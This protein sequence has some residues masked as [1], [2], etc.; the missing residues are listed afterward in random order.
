MG[1]EPPSDDPQKIW[2]NQT[3]EIPQMTLE[4]VHEVKAK[5]LHRKTR[6]ESIASPA[7][8]ILMCMIVLAIAHGTVQRIACG[9]AILWTMI[10]QFPTIRRTW[11]RPPAGDEAS[12]TSLEFYRRELQHRLAY[13]RKPWRVW[14]GIIVP[15]VLVAGAL[16][17]PG[18]IAVAQ[19]PALF[20]NM[21]PF[22]TL[23][24]IWVVLLFRITRQQV[25]QIQV[26]LTELD[27][28]ER[29]QRS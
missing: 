23:M 21:V 10:V 5:A 29:W 1:N 8:M 4:E 14:G 11:L 7:A 26:E 17:Y 20:I 16:V 24:A 13:F 6:W 2:Q 28:L 27:A 3:T 22:L 18:I 9:L 25:R 12:L 15:V 19:K